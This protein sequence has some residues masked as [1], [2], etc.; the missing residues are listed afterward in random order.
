[1]A[2]Y[3]AKNMQL[4]PYYI[5]S[6]QIRQDIPGFTGTGNQQEIRG[7]SGLFLDWPALEKSGAELSGSCVVA[8]CKHMVDH[9]VDALKREAYK[10]G[11]CL[12]AY[13]SD[14]SV[15]EDY[16]RSG[17]Q[18]AVKSFGNI[19]NVLLYA[20]H[21][22]NIN[23]SNKTKEDLSR[24]MDSGEVFRVLVAYDCE[25]NRY[26]MNDMLCDVGVE[27]DFVSSGFEI[28]EKLHGCEYNLVLLDIQMPGCPDLTKNCSKN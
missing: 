13:D 17:F 24:F 22:L 18:L 11:V 5:I 12:I 23:L 10:A 21:I 1:M 27:A 2:E 20:A 9:Q 26:V 19:E 8:D 16:Y 15:H 7:A 28:I 14:D 25:V 4:P 3:G 6:E